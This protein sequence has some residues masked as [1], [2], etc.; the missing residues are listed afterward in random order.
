MKHYPAV[1]L[2]QLL[3][4][5]LLKLV[6]INI[7]CYLLLIAFHFLLILDSYKQI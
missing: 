5:P 7:G 2:M 6:A 3:Y 4:E 1:E